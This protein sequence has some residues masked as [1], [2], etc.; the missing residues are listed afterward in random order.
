MSSEYVV[1]IG[2]HPFTPLSLNH[3]VYNLHGFNY[4]NQPRFVKFRDAQ[5]ALPGFNQYLFVANRFMDET[6]SRFNL[7]RPS[8]KARLITTS[9][10]TP[11]PMG[12]SYSVV[13][14]VIQQSHPDAKFI[15]WGAEAHIF[16]GKLVGGCIKAAADELKLP[17]MEVNLAACHLI[18]LSFEDM[19]HLLQKGLYNATQIMQLL[20]EN[21]DPNL[22]KLVQTRFDP[23]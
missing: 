2:I 14:D 15:L 18:P 19:L 9:D 5:L 23:V 8:W 1:H 12:R 10:A 17:N 13:S 4:E 20:T 11:R 21:G 3:D 16:K 7:N 6:V 22:E